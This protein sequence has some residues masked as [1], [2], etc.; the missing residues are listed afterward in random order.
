MLGSSWTQF[1]APGGK[2]DTHYLWPLF[3]YLSS[4]IQFNSFFFFSILWHFFFTPIIQIQKK[5]AQHWMKDWRVCQEPEIHCTFILRLIAAN[6]SRWKQRKQEFDI[7][8]IC[9]RQ[10][11]TKFCTFSE[12]TN[13]KTVKNF[14]NV[15]KLNEHITLHMCS[16]LYTYVHTYILYLHLYLQFLTPL[17]I[18]QCECGFCATLI[19][20]K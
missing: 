3:M 6:R 1:P 18:K 4:F 11:N 17:F 16:Y 20:F 12:K 14:T 2:K 7:K 19:R 5:S 13:T 9:T 8:W 15:C 10:E